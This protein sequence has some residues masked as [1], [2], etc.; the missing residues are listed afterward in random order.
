M[1]FSSTKPF[2]PEGLMS[3]SRSTSWYPWA[4]VALLWMVALLNYLDRQ[5]IVTMGDP[6][7]A[8]L[9]IQNTQFGMLNTVFLWIYASCSLVAGFL[10]DRFGRRRIIFLS[11]VIWSAATLWTGFASSFYELLAARAVMG[12]S[13]AFYLPAAVALV[14]D[15][16]RGRTRSLAT[17]LH[18]SGIYAGSI[19]GGLGGWMATEYG[20]RFGFELFGAFGIGYGILLSLCLKNP[21]AENGCE[22]HASV[23]SPKP[24][25]LATFRE[26]LGIKSFLFLLAAAACIG[27]A[28]WTIRSWMP[29]FFQSELNVSQTRAG[30]YGATILSIANFIGML[31]GGVLSDRW[32]ILNPRVR[33]IIP[34]IGYC[35]AAPC[36]LALGFFPTVYV[37]QMA[38]FVYG[39]AQGLQDSNLMPAVCNVIRSQHRATAYGLLNFVGT[40]FGGLMTLVGGW[41]S[42][43]GVSFALFFQCG[44]LVI[45]GVGLFLFAAS[46]KKTEFSP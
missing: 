8:E 38:V 6:I 20:W 3:K 46:P 4:V 5:L 35:F 34:G 11:I 44:S 22:T 28:G 42:D 30:I 2:L 36:F 12:F 24:E 1:V 15:F 7:K 26:L 16:H 18:L 19:L 37:V 14:V 40:S 41:L 21:P 10:A 9:N 45:L 32:A 23:S 39:I 17:G 43:Q 29:L 33:T 25:I 27:S 13:E 31:V